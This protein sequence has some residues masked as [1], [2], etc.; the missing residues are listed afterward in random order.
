MLY[1]FFLTS[2][3]MVR[4]ASKKYAFDIVHVHV[5]SS[6]ASHVVTA[7]SVHIAGTVRAG[8]QMGGLEKLWSKARH[9]EPLV[10]YL[11]KYNF[12]KKRSRKIIA[13]SESVRQE[14]IS[15]VGCSP[16]KID[17][18]HNGV[19]L[20]KFKRTSIVRDE[21]RKRLG[22][23]DDEVLILFVANEFRRKGLDYLIRALA[24]MNR[25]GIPFKFVV[26]GESSDH[27]MTGDDCLKIV[28]ARGLGEKVT[29][30]GRVSDVERYFAASDVFI[31]PTQYEPFGLVITE[32]MAAGLPVVVSKLAGAAELIVDGVNGVLLDD[33]F[34]ET[35]IMRKV[36]D[37]LL[38]P[39]KMKEM[40]RN[41]EE[42]IEKYSW[43]FV[44]NETMK[45]YQSLTR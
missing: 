26:A 42:T 33:P 38:N 2:G 4:R 1:S 31:L 17:V 40:G 34:N 43:D 44:T 45:L 21:V 37:L 9:C 18:I 14:L 6:C 36:S 20:E 39:S 12:L 25:R 13:I 23:R 5:P 3:F 8:K 10:F 35:E 7:H 24:S 30:L 27:S 16:G 28:Q 11:S 29:F 19:N 32:A 41:A 22:A 15:F